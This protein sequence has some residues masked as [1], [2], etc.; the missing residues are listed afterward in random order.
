LDDLENSGYKSIRIDSTWIYS[1][2]EGDPIFSIG[3]S[4]TTSILGKLNLS[5]AIHNWSSQYVSLPTISFGNIAM[6]NSLLHFFWGDLSIYPGNSGGPVIKNNKLIGIISGQAQY[7]G[8]RVP[9]AYV[10]KIKHLFPLLEEQ[11]KKDK[12]FLEFIGK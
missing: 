9:F 12:L 4:I 7:D 2:N 5:S 1:L 3:Y 8:Q 11:I 10:I 6:N